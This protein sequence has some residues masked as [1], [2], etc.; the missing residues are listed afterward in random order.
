MTDFSQQRKNMVESQVRPSDVTDRRITTAMSD[1]PRER[2]VPKELAQLAYMDEALPV[3][4]GRGLMAPRDFARLV[5]LAAIEDTDKVLVVGA[6]RGYS[7][8]VL[9]RLSREVVALECDAEASALTK[10]LLDELGIGNV[11]AVTGPLAAG[12]PAHAPYDAIVVEG[13][14]DTPPEA[15][16]SQLSPVG[17][18]VAV[19]NE[20]GVGRAIV[21]LKSGQV[22]AKRVAFEA[23][24]PR[25]PGFERP[26][27]FVF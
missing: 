13:A 20:A 24:A 11:H 27:S 7:A 3:A 21:L 22:S 19:Q 10:P 5:Q 17:R 23:A 14:I 6:G 15:L 16:I 1:L 18:L 25:L 12:W 8:A 2:F 9:S 26:A 4:P